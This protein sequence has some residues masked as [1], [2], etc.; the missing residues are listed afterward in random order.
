MESTASR[1][2]G[3]ILGVRRT[4]LKIGGWDMKLTGIILI[5]LQIVSF[6]PTLVRG[7]NIFAN[8]IFNLIGR[9]SFGIVGIILLII[10]EKR[11]NKTEAQPEEKSETDI[12]IEQ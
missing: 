3:K 10:A 12:E 6:V 2:Y 9:L 8:G 1:V 5:V 7:D 4:L 11:K